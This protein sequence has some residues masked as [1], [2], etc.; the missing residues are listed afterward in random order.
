MYFQ[1]SSISPLNRKVCVTA[2][3]SCMVYGL[4]NIPRK[5][6]G[7]Q[8]LVLTYFWKAKVPPVKRADVSG[9]LEAE[10]GGLQV[11]TCLLE[12]KDQG[13]QV[14]WE[15]RDNW[16]SAVTVFPVFHYEWPPWRKPA[17]VSRCP[18]TLSVL[19]GDS[20]PWFNQYVLFTFCLLAVS[21]HFGASTPGMWDPHSS[22][23][24]GSLVRTLSRVW[25]TPSP[26]G[27]VEKAEEW[28]PGWNL[29]FLG[30]F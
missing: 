12:S 11:C 3:Q 5:Y 9:H 27:R 15:Q 21:H 26:K 14:K 6:L 8:P 22:V 2:D 4:R 10:A 13:V 23:C 18:V 7:T 25:I 19:W 16:R 28:G 17:F 29:W 24:L 30:C 20:W 1:L